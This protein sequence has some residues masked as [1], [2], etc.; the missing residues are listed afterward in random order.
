MTVFDVAE[1][2]GYAFQTTRLFMLAVTLVAAH[3]RRDWKVLSPVDD[4][5]AGVPVQHHHIIA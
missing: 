2:A 1:M 4:M 3:Q 5:A